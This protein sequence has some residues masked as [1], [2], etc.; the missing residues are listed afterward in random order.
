MCS[1]VYLDI[2]RKTNVSHCEIIGKKSLAVNAFIYYDKQCIYL[3]YAINKK[4][5]GLENMTI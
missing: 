2:L 3:V 4:S 1:I 5:L